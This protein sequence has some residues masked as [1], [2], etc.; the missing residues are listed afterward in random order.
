MPLLALPPSWVA[1][2]PGYTPTPLFLLLLEQLAP[3][4]DQDQEEQQQQQQGATSS[5]GSFS[6]TWWEVTL[7]V[8]TAAVEAGLDAADD[9]AGAGDTDP[10]DA[11]SDGA[12]SDPEISATVFSFFRRHLV[13]SPAALPFWAPLAA[14]AGA[15]GRTSP[16]HLA[17]Q[18]QHQQQAGVMERLADLGSELDCAAFMARCHPTTITA[19]AVHIRSPAA[20]P[21]AL[22]GLASDL[23]VRLERLRQQVAVLSSLGH[24]FRAALQQLAVKSDAR[25]K[26]GR[27]CSKVL[28]GSDYLDH[29]L[30]T[31]A[32]NQLLLLRSWDVAAEQA[33][34]ELY[35]DWSCDYDG[36]ID[37]D[38][39]S[40]EDEEG[41]EGPGHTA[42]LSQ[43]QQQQQARASAPS[44]AAGGR[45]RGASSRRRVTGKRQ[46]QQMPLCPP[47]SKEDPIQWMD[48]GGR[49]FISF[50]VLSPEAIDAVDGDALRD[51]MIAHGTWITSH[52]E[53]VASQLALQVVDIQSKPWFDEFQALWEALEVA[54]Q[55]R[56]NQLHTTLGQEQEVVVEGQGAH[57]E[58]GQGQHAS[59]S[60]Q[61]ADG[62]WRER[63]RRHVCR[64]P[65]GAAVSPP[66]TRPRCW[67][68]RAPALGRWRWRLR[69][70]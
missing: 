15:L 24:R 2:V 52:S 17:H 43:Q 6:S 68:Q 42:R 57:K 21:W 28:Y 22:Y 34:A 60:A 65:A 13:P 1:L 67:Q 49:I 44:A 14:L 66:W 54:R 53:W 35:E 63:R 59:S 3:A 23:G 31:L 25:R 41:G 5:S 45:S 51:S 46:P 36:S 12:D 20:D 19:Y 18:Q 26:L 64:M 48:N 62:D 16:Q 7:Q 8:L 4:A 61:D 38:S 39:S 33:L 55:K 11:A 9:T 50:P 29:S 32:S 58:G 56:L 70:C 10:T 30:A 27:A 37:D 40:S 69:C 47:E